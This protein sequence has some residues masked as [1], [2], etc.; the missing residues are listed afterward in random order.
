MR[1]LTLV[2]A[3]SAIGLSLSG[4]ASAA[5][6]G[7]LFSCDAEGTNNT[8]GAVVGGLVGALAGSQVSKRDRGLGAVIGAGVGAAIGNSVGCRMDRKAQQDARQAFQRALDTGRPQTR[9]DPNTGVSGRVEVLGDAA[10]GSRLASR[11][12]RG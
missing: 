9:A 6:L 12:P 1:S 7:S 11:R 2:L 4:P 8:T 3:V 10:G 5:G